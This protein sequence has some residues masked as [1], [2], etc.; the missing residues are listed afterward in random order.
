MR[1]SFRRAFSTCSRLR[2]AR[3]PAARVKLATVHQGVQFEERSHQ[4]LGS[5]MSMAL[6]RVGGK[7]DGGVDLQGWWWLP[8]ASSS[9]GPALPTGR[10][11]D[12]ERRRI[13]VLGQCK[14]ERVKLGPHYV[15]EMEGVMLALRSEQEAAP[16]APPAAAVALLVSESGFTRGGLE[17]ARQSRVPFFLMHL[18]PRGL[19]VDHPDAIGGCIW[20]PALANLLGPAFEV[21][22]ERAADPDAPAPAPAPARPGIWWNGKR[23]PNWTPGRA[24]GTR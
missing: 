22:W 20:N 10:D 5:Q 6:A 7:S 1:P 2:H 19:A 24:A 12:P 9:P 16:D 23:L 21:R 18:P 13:Q 3:A 17:R 11:W 14:A 8:P 15:R 4:V